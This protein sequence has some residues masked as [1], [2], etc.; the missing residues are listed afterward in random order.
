MKKTGSIKE[1]FQ[2]YWLALLIAAQPVLD[3]LAYWTRSPD[4]TA[5]GLLR[6][7]IMVIL[8]RGGH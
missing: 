4:G 8:P 7:A 5:A 3:A 6:L 2:K 1:L